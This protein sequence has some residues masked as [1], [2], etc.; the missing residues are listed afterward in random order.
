MPKV[1]C[2]S[3][4]NS[5]GHLL[6]PYLEGGVLLHVPQQMWLLGCRVVA[7]SALELLPWKE[8]EDKVSNA[9]WKSRFS[10]GLRKATRPVVRK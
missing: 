8:A 6:R 4:Q 10:E 7:H 3:S 5:R 9:R 1:V 2:V